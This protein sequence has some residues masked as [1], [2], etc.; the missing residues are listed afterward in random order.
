MTRTAKVNIGVDFSQTPYG[1]YPKDGPYNGQVFRKKIMLP[2]MSDD[3]VDCMGTQLIDLFRIIV[4][5]N[6][7]LIDQFHVHPLYAIRE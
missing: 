3:S 2:L 1:R 6:C 7:R 5:R 4:W